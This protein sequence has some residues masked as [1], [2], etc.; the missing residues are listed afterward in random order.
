MI[1][2]GE[3][4]VETVLKWVDRIG[5]FLLGGIVGYIIRWLITK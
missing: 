2:L 5:F 4:V 3:K 1:D